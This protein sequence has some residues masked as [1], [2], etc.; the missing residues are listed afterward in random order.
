MSEAARAIE[1]LLQLMAR[2]RDPATG[3]PWDREQSFATIAPYTLE[4]AYEV[5]DAI[6]RGDPAQLRDE[7]GDLLFQIVFHARLAEERGWFAFAQVAE[8]IHAKLVR[9]HPHVF[10]GTAVRD[11]QQQSANWEE[12]KAAER[13]ERAQAQQAPDTSALAGIPRALPALARAAKL[14]RRAARVGFDWQEPAQVRDKVLEEL[15]EVDEALAPSAEPADAVRAQRIAEELGDLL[16]AI[17]NW[18]LHLKVDPEEALRAANTKFEQR[19]RLMEGMARERG[20][21][22]ESLDAAAW[23]ELWR[24]AKSS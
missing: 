18:T 15:R 9:R 2:L 17:A 5:A 7:L 6:D 20:S 3:C 10:A 16:F 21:P 13:A 1:A 22:L 8:S 11:S 24:R 12:L 4:E 23:D 14:G 19:F